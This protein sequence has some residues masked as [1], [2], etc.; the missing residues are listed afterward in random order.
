MFKMRCG[1]PNAYILDIFIYVLNGSG[2][3][4]LKI[5]IHNEFPHVS[6]SHVAM[7]TDIFIPE[8]GNMAGRNVNK[9]FCI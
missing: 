5:N 1:I 8:E 6:A 4:T 7:I 2:R 9:S 3:Q